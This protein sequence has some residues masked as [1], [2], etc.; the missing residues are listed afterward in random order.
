M[1]GPYGSVADRFRDIYRGKP[2]VCPD[3]KNCT[4]IHNDADPNTGE[5]HHYGCECGWCMYIYWSLK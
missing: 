2:L 4:E 5:E 1:S 3:P